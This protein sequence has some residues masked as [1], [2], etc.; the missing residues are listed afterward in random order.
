MNFVS[1]LCCFGLSHIRLMVDTEGVETT[2]R[3]S[4]VFFWV[5]IRKVLDNGGI[6]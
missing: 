5:D 4:K 3:L 2:F 6:H 1:Q